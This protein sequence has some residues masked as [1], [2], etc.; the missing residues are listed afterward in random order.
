MRALAHSQGCTAPF[1]I[2][3]VSG[4]NRLDEQL[5]DAPGIS[6]GAHEPLVHLELEADILTRVESSAKVRRQPVGHSAKRVVPSGAEVRRLV[7]EAL[8]A[9]CREHA[10]GTATRIVE[11]A[12]VGRSLDTAE[13][14]RE[15]VHCE[16]RCAARAPRFPNQPFDAAAMWRVVPRQQQGTLA[17]VEMSGDVGEEARVTGRAVQVDE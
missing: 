2:P 13:N 11:Q 16:V 7:A 6:R 14:G 9:S 1:S 15:R 3:G 5:R 8:D 12:D 4:E 17:V 10:L